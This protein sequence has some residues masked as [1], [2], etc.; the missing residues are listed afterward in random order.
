[1]RAPFPPSP[2]IRPARFLDKPPGDRGMLSRV[3]AQQDARRRHHVAMCHHAHG[4]HSSGGVALN[5]CT[6]SRTAPEAKSPPVA[7]SRSGVSA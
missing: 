6:A 1:M 5:Q 3:M 2:R 7:L 4:I